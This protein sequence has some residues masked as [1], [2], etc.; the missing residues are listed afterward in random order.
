L[1]VNFLSNFFGYFYHFPLVVLLFLIPVIFS[2]LFYFMTLLCTFTVLL[3]GK[4]RIMSRFSECCTMQQFL[5]ESARMFA[6]GQ[7]ATFTSPFLILSIKKLLT[8][9][10]HVLLPLE[11][12]GF[13]LIVLYFVVLVYCCCWY[14]GPFAARNCCVQIIC[15]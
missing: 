10:C 9:K 11:S 15:P 4:L 3:E 8:F 13:M 2:F 5:N 6:V 12:F 1:S 14:I 7:F